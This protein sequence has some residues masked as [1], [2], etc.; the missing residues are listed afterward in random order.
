[1]ISSV[2][3][4]KPSRQIRQPVFSFKQ[5][6]ARRKIIIKYTLLYLVV[7]AFFAA[8]IVLPVVFRNQID[9]LNF[10]IGL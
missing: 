4:L 3:W 6:T 2:F 10:D 5:K 7:I 1:M 9:S 8:L